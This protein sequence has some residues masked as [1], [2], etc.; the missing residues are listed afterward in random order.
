MPNA[1]VAATKRFARRTS[2]ATGL[3]ATMRGGGSELPATRP[4]H[5]ATPLAQSS[6]DL[7]ERSDTGDVRVAAI[8]TLRDLGER[9]R[10][11]ESI[12]D[13]EMRTI[14]GLKPID[15]PHLITSELCRFRFTAPAIFTDGY[16]LFDV[17][18]NS[19]DNLNL[20]PLCRHACTWRGSAADDPAC[21]PT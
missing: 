5:N 11:G 21:P 8:E 2:V 4:L 10:Q 12:S 19:P 7:S 13:E 9:M 6:G 3:G 17:S 16:W 14:F 1:A 18:T 20:C 15:D